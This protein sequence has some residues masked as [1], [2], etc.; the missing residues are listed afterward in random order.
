MSG[1]VACVLT[2]SQDPWFWARI[3]DRVGLR[4]VNWVV[5]GEEVRVAF[6]GRHEHALR[7]IWLRQLRTSGTGVL[8]HFS[9][10]HDLS[11]PCPPR[12]TQG[13]QRSRHGRFRARPSTG[14]HSGRTATVLWQ[15]SYC[16]Q[17]GCAGRASR[18]RRRPRLHLRF[19][20]RVQRHAPACTFST[21]SPWTLRGPWTVMRRLPMSAATERRP[22]RD[23]LDRHLGAG[24]SYRRKTPRAFKDSIAPT[25]LLSSHRDHVS[26]LFA[27]QEEPLR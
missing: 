16:I 23:A 21:S 14:K 8:H 7:E 13:A 1:V 6:R 11:S 12:R 3:D 20:S 9:I 26:P 19:R 10:R 22:S 25:E 18:S 4:G 2:V 5:G 15:R 27:L 17:H 24:R